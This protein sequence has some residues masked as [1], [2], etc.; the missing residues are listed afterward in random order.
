MDETDRDI[1][2]CLRENARTPVAAIAKRLDLARST[3]QSRLER[4]ESSGAIE[5]Y[6]VRVSSAVRARPI[7]ASALLEI[8]PRKLVAVMARL[9]Q[10]DSI[11]SVHTTSGRIDLLVTIAARTTEELDKALDTIGEIDGVTDSESLIHLTTKLDR[12]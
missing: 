5:G 11:E 6:T 12:R 7:R 1:L 10:I 9:R 2:R 8:E 3:V 4:L